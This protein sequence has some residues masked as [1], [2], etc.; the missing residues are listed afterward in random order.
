[1]VF[2]DYASTNPFTKYECSDYCRPFFNANANY[3]FVEK[4]MLDEAEERIKTAIGAKGGKVVF[5]GTASQLVENLMNCNGFSNGADFWTIGSAYEHDSV[6]RFSFEH[7][8]HNVA[9]LKTN[10]R[11]FKPTSMR[12]IVFWQGANNV[13]GMLM[14]IEE[15]GKLCKKYN[16]FFLCDATALVGHAPIPANIDKWCSAFWYSGHKIGTELGIGAM[17]LSEDFND[18]LGDFKLHGT[19]NVAGALSIADATE[20]AVKDV[21]N[22]MWKWRDLAELLA[23]ELNKADVLV[24]GVYFKGDRTHAINAIR[25]NGINADALQQYLASKQ[26]YVGLGVSACAES[27]DYRVLNAF[28]LS[29]GEASEVIRVSFG[30]DS[31]EKDVFNLVRG[32]KEFKEKYL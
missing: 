20:D 9:E 10:L 13:T 22:N 7:D 26:I 3:A 2:L 1:M 19:P 8:L 32:I 29:D 16:A 28:G 27:H 23:G 4:Q 11:T 14:P 15:I 18:W 31:T 5:G 24:Q 12:P 30:E 21:N 25:L 17:W 6:D